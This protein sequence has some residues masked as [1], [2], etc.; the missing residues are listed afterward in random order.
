MIVQKRDMGAQMALA[1]FDL[2]P[3]YQQTKRKLNDIR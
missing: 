2:N 3:V 1:S